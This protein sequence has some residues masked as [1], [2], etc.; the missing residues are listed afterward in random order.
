MAM[1]L[2]YYLFDEET[3]Y[4]G[5]SEELWILRNV[6]VDKIEET[7]D[8]FINGVFAYCIKHKEHYPIFLNQHDPILFG[9]DKRFSKFRKLNFHSQSLAN[10]IIKDRTANSDSK[11]WEYIM[12]NPIIVSF[13]D[14]QEAMLFKINFEF[15][16]KPDA[17]QL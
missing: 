16:W 17:G 1:T 4:W 2:E 9:F 6:F 12:R 14:E 7:F 15:E 13:D 8:K 3:R 10:R 5:E 11:T